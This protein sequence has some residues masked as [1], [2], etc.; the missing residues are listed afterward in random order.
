MA[1]PICPAAGWLG[2]LCGGY[3]GI[4]PPKHPGGRLFSATITA[5]L[6]G[7]TVIALKSI[8]NVS[9]CVGGTFTA[10]NIVRVG[11]KTLVMG[12]I[13]SIG[14]NYILN[15]YVFFDPKDHPKGGMDVEIIYESDDSP[16]YCCK[17]KGK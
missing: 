13:Y 7:V 4:E 11:S 6:I 14:V 3:L 16:P 17:K 8:F 9:L 12:I 15:R 10:A 2:G 1:C 5:S